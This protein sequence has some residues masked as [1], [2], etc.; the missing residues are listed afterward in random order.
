MRTPLDDIDF[1]RLTQAHA[2]EAFAVTCD[3][4]ANSSVLHQAMDVGLAEYRHYLRASFDAIWRQN[5]SL[6]AIDRQYDHVVGCVVAC[7]YFAQP[8]YPCDAPDS[9]KPIKALLRQLE[10]LAADSRQRDAGHTLLVDM[11]IVKPEYRGRGIYRTLRERVHESGY[12]AGFTRVLGELSSTAAQRT[13]IEHF[14]HTVVAE[15]KFAEF[16]YE[17]CKPFACIT[18]PPS[19]VLVEGPLTGPTTAHR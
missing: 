9:L 7:D 5:L 11:A 4:F 19:L 15:I 14:G 1:V 6:V 18:D 3:V 16:E 17:G 2:E 10:A 8:D 12:N 13:C